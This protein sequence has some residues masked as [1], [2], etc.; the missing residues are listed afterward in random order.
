MSKSLK[1]FIT[2]REALST[3]NARQLRLMFVL[4]PWHKTMIYGEQSRAEMKAREAQLKNFFQNVKA[5]VRTA[6]VKT[7]E[8]RWLE[9]LSDK[10]S[11][12]D[13]ASGEPTHDKE[14]KPLEGKVGGWVEA[15]GSWE[16]GDSLRLEVKDKARK[17]YEK[18]AKVREPLAKKLAEGPGAVEAMRAEVE[19]MR[20]QVAAMQL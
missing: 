17:D 6:D 19:E 14:G 3:F 20:R 8:Q 16:V 4:Q 7:T 2:I 5:A 1:N 13:A 15:G 9:A 11:Q 12:F 10:Y 18:A